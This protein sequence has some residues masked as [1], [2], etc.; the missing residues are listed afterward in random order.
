MYAPAPRT[1]DTPTPQASPPTK[2]RAVGVHG[3]GAGQRTHCC[4]GCEAPISFYG[5]CA[6]CLHVYCLAC[7]SEMAQCYM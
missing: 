7:A 6:P 3:R 4:V 2:D 5:R 1:I